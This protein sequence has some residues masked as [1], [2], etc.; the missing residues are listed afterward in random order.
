MGMEPTSEAWERTGARSVDSVRA[1][2]QQETMLG[3]AKRR[4]QRIVQGEATTFAA[5]SGFPR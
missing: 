2:I 5:D 1:V 4:W 3:F